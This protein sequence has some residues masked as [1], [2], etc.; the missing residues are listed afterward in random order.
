MWC[1]ALTK[2]G[3]QKFELLL[4][5][6]VRLLLDICMTK[7]R[8]RLVS[9]TFRHYLPVKESWATRLQLRLLSPNGQNTVKDLIFREIPKQYVLSFILFKFG[10]ISLQLLLALPSEGTT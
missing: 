2:Y 4:S 6:N 5:T 10:M 1:Q 9:K 3:P 8:V 7:A